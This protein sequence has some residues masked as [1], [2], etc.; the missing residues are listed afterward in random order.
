MGLSLW[1]RKHLLRRFTEPMLRDGYDTYE[2]YDFAFKA[3]VQTTSRV[4]NTFEDGDRNV[5]SLKVFSDLEIHVA[6]QDGLPADMLWFQGKWFECRSSRLSENTFL[7]HWTSTF[8]QCLNQL[9]PPD[10]EVLRL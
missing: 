1:K 10:L 6:S 9:E 2:C 8:V 7:K 5:Q 4:T 3:D